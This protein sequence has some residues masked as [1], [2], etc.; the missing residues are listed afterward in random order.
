MRSLFITTSLVALAAAT[1]GSHELDIPANLRREPGPAKVS[2][3]PSTPAPKTAPVKSATKK[4]STKPA[5]KKA[6]AKV[7]AAVAEA[8]SDN[9]R[10]IVPKKFKAIYAAHDGTNGDKLAAALKLATTTKNE[11]GRECLDEPA[12]AKIAKENGVDYAAYKHLNNGQK[13]MNV[14]NKLRGMLKGGER[15]QIGKQVFAD[16]KK[17]LAKPETQV[18]A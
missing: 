8:Q 17:A 11:D 13:R 2:L 6:S 12:L 7:E 9:R 4:A 14:G 5:S 1:E 15:V 16:A 10:S 3:A 18:S